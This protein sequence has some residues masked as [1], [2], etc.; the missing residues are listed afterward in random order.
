[1]EKNYQDCQNLEAR[2]AGSRVKR[3]LFDNRLAFQGGVAL[4]S[5]DLHPQALGP[6]AL[7]PVLRGVRDLFAPG[8][9]HTHGGKL[10]LKTKK[11]TPTFLW[12][13]MRQDE[14]MTDYLGILG[15]R[16]GYLKDD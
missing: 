13:L 5:E 14:V 10:V 4:L 1:M 9:R 8:L 16:I 2:T 11:Q 12:L 3:N 15:E 7:C 6:R